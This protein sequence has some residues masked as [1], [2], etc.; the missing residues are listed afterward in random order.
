VRKA[1]EL[2]Q[3]AHHRALEIDVGVVPSDDARIH[4]GGRQRR[5]DPGGGGRRVDPAEE[6]RVAVAHGVGQDV[7]QGGRDQVVERGRAL[8]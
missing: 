8:R 3:P 7:A 1:D 5:D 2:G 4:R 6:G